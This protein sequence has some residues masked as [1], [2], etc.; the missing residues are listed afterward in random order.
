MTRPTW[1]NGMLVG[2]GLTL[3][4]HPIQAQ[5]IDMMGNIGVSGTLMQQDAQN[6]GAMNK[7]MRAQRFMDDISFK[8]AE[9]LTTFMGDY[10][11]LPAQ[12][13]QSSG[14]TVTVKPAENGRTF[15]MEM[16]AV[17]ATL[18]KQII[19]R[20]W[21]GLTGQIV[22]GKKYAPSP[23][24]NRSACQATNTISLIFQ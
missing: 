9:I 19:A 1:I 6:I 17:N 24:Q 3:C 13:F 2:A 20:R 10:R 7:S 8:S 21:D 15:A 14:V 16:N 18:C 4:L 22:N 11:N 12:S 23:I 5:M